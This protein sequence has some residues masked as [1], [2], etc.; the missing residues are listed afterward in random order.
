MEPRACGAQGIGPLLL[1]E[2][3]TPDGLRVPIVSSLELTT[4]RAPDTPDPPG[5]VTV[6]DSE[7]VDPSFP[8]GSEHANIARTARNARDA[9]ISFSFAQVQALASMPRWAARA[10]SNSAASAVLHVPASASRS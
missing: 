5:A 3:D 10:R 6:P 2:N 1:V 4:I 9:F 7:P 8:V